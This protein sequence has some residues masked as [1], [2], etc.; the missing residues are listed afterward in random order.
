[1]EKNCKFDL[2]TCA[3]KS[4]ESADYMQPY[5]YKNHLYAIVNR[6]HIKK[7]K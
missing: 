3:L 6:I 5:L 1:M 2:N 7:S 4:W